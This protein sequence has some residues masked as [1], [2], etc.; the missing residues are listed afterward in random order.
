VKKLCVLANE[1]PFGI[2]EPY[3]ETEELF[4]SSFDKVWICSLQLRDKDSKKQ[5]PLRN[6]ETVIPVMYKSKLFYLINSITVLFDTQLYKEINIL[7]KKRTKVIPRIIN[8]FVYLSRAHHEARVIDRNMKN[9][10]KKDIMLYSYRFEYQPYVALL[11][12]R[13]WKTDNIIVSRAHGYDLYE[14]RHKNNYIPL[15]KYILNNVDCVFPCSKNGVNY[16]KEK[17]GTCRCKVSESYLGTVNHYETEYKD[18]DTF[19]IVS[20]SNVVKVKR[21][22]KIIGALSLIKDI[23]ISWTHYGD[24]SLLNEM[25]KLAS[26]K[27]KDN[28]QFTFTGNV[29]NSDLLKEYSQNNYNLFINTSSSE[30]LPVSIMEAISFGIPCLA[31][32]V[33][34]TNEIINETNGILINSD[35]SDEKIAEEIRKVYLLEK[36]NYLILRRNARYYWDC[37]FNAE[38]NYKSFIQKLLMLGQGDN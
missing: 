33:G 18:D 24:G 21:I 23:N 11:L 31:T 19:K 7:L 27:L 6:G 2:W 37:N 10:D 22:E 5:R 32:D 15:R 8:L 16:I 30:G 4:Y 36:E 20:C 13:K 25:K 34:G 17:Y 38:K 1:F 14:E 9:E 35:V 3:M 29:S 28:I 12:K 26:E